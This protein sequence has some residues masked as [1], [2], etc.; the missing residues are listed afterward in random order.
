LGYPTKVQLIKRKESEQWYI[1][2]PSAVARAMEFE[3][4]E[5]VE[6][7]IEDKGQLV[8]QRLQVPP[9]ARKK[10]RLE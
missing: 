1:N 8:L 7:I 4:G 2:F 5:I 9:S 10:K 3:R 6:W